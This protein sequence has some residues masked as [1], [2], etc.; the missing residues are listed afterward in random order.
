[1]IGSCL[2]RNYPI[3]SSKRPVQSLPPI[4]S[5]LTARGA[6]RSSKRRRRHKTTGTSA[7]YHSQ[8]ES[9]ARAA[10]PPCAD[11]WHNADTVAAAAA[12]ARR[13]D[14]SSTRCAAGGDRHT[15][16]AGPRTT[17]GLDRVLHVRPPVGAA[18]APA[19]RGT[20]ATA[21]PGTRPQSRD[22]ATATRR[23]GAGGR[24][25]A[26]AAPTADGDGDQLV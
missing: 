22:G 13:I 5:F 18:P 4:R 23:I 6:Y 24:R 7:Q 9:Q 8:I 19:P 11:K 12:Q 3:C 15:G 1:M 25:Q 2:Q 14:E 20:W 17:T 16:T 26:V 21:G 10:Q